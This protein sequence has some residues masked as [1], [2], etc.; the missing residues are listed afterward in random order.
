M[1]E[2]TGH[3]EAIA[4]NTRHV[5]ELG[6]KAGIARVDIE[7]LRE[8][9]CELEDSDTA[10][11]AEHSQ[12]RDRL[13]VNDNNIMLIQQHLHQ[14]DRWADGRAGSA[15]EKQKNYAHTHTHT[16]CFSVQRTQQ[17]PVAA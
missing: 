3:E 12:Q 5:T 9:T 4:S 17:S 10:M 2:H 14:L 11:R 7:A 15:C 8:R 1:P 13:D 6:V 16:T